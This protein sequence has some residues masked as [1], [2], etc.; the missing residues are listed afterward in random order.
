MEPDLL[1]HLM[2]HAE[3]KLV[4][5]RFLVR[6]RRHAA[7]E[8]NWASTKRPQWASSTGGKRATWGLNL[9]A[10]GCQVVPIGHQP[11]TEILLLKQNRQMNS[12]SQN[13]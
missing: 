7:N 1:Q 12:K 8:A 10:V 9:D 13:Q 5:E 11:G 6:L 2:H 4:R 3:Q